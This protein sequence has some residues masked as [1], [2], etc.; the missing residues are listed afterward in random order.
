MLP[1]VI[2]HSLVTVDGNIEGFSPEAICRYYQLADR[3][4]CDTW[5]VESD[6]LLSAERMF[7]MQ[8]HPRDRNGEPLPRVRAEGGAEHPLRAGRGRARGLPL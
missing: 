8:A 4:D 6:T 7:R 5:L 3:L 2:M 1:A